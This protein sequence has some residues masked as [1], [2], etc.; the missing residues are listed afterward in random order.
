MLQEHVFALESLRFYNF[1]SIWGTSFEKSP[2]QVAGLGFSTKR[3]PK[4]RV[5]R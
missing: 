3:G 1:E 4:V 5:S 2:L